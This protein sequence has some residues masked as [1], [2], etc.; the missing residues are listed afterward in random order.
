MVGFLR[1]LVFSYAV[2]VTTLGA[3]YQTA[4]TIPNII[5][6]IVAN[7][8]LAALVVPLVAGA[9]ARG[10]RDELGR[11]AS[12]LLTWVLLLLVPV[13]GVVVAVAHPVIWLLEPHGTPAELRVGAAMLRVFAP[14]LP[15]YGVGIIL[16]GVLQAHRRF[17]WPVLAPLLSSLTVIGAYLCF[18]A[19]EP[20]KIDIPFVGRGGELILSVGT[21]LGVVVLSLSLVVP[22]RRLGLRLRPTLRLTGQ[23]RRS[24]RGL[25]WVGVITAAAQQLSLALAIALANW[26]TPK[27]SLVLFTQAQTLYLVPWAVL[28]VPV[29]TSAY[30]ALATAVATGAAQRFRDT[31]ASATRSV[32]LLCALGASAL[33]ALAWPMAWILAHLAK[34]PQIG[35]LAAAIAGFAPG[36]FGYGL[37]ALHSRALYARRDNRWAAVA[38]LTGWGAV[39]GASVLLA[40]LL[41]V[42][43]RVPALTAANSAGMLVLGAM[44]MVLVRRRAGAGALAGV[45]RAAGTAVL[46]GTLAAAVGILVRW[47]LTGAV[48]DAAARAHPGGTPGYPRVVLAGMLSGV[49][50]AV[51]FAGVVLVVDRRD[52]RPMLARLVGRAMPAR[53]GAD[54]AG[55][56]PGADL[57]AEADLAAP[58]DRTGGDR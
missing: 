17:A 26:D 58:V 25:A 43:D 16:S 40:V 24:V 51:V 36:L 30:P 48:W 5:F 52:A 41:P 22:V 11:T 7:G 35:A 20:S 8:A 45:R 18:A 39:A 46:A 28:A 27:G 2:G 4:N 21:T 32:L 55:P 56:T 53:A 10:D 54:P 6:E 13:A 33:V 23:A 49:A 29:A 31:L 9:V 12:G 3:V 42:R 19:V 38:T 57:P 14:Q 34:T 47:P 50:V 44:M 37:F 1:I 15:L